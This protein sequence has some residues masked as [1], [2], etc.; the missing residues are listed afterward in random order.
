MTAGKTGACR[1]NQ[2]GSADRHTLSAWIHRRIPRVDHVLTGKVPETWLCG[3]RRRQPG[4]VSVGRAQFLQI[5]V[6]RLLAQ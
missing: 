5:L 2:S 6:V 3:Q 1:G 4:V